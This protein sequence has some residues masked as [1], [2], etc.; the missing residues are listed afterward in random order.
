VAIYRHSRSIAAV[1]VRRYQPIAEALV[2][3]AVTFPLAVGLHVPTLWLLTPLAL[4][5]FTKRPYHTYGLTWEQP[6]SLVFHVGVGLVVFVPYVIGHYAWAHWWLGASFHLRWP[7]AF[8]ESAI[9]Q[10]L[11]IALPEEF[12]FRGYFQ[13]ECD[14]AFG[15]PYRCLGTNYGPGLLLAA[16]AFAACHVPF[17]GPARLIVFFPGLLYGWLRARTS[18]IAVPVAYHAVSNLLMSIMLASLG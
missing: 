15:K 9:D 5:T 10:V 3:L 12:F 6:G 4:L 14:R 16:A 18:T 11:A 2:L 8:F 1:S 17:G 13:T 7:P